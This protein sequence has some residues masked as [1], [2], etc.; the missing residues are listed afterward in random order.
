MAFPI[1]ALIGMSILSGLQNAGEQKKM[2]QARAAELAANQQMPAAGTQETPD[3][4]APMLETALAE[5]DATDDEMAAA[6]EA[7]KKKP[8]QKQPSEAGQFFIDAFSGRK[9]LTNM[10]LS[11]MFGMFG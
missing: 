10:L 8:K 6:V 3:L 7:E 1:A 9:P 5:E 4:G 2:A 11:K